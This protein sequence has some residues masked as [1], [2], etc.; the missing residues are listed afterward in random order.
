MVPP[1]DRRKTYTN[2]TPLFYGC[3]LALAAIAGLGWSAIGNPFRLAATEVI[4]LGEVRL[5][6]VAQGVI[7]VKNRHPW[8]AASVIGV[9]TDCSCVS[10]QPDVLIVPARTNTTVATTVSPRANQTRVDAIV[11]FMQT[12][13]RELH[14]KV[15]ATVVSP[16]AGWPDAAF[17]E[18]RDGMLIVSLDERYHGLVRSVQCYAPDGAG[19]G[20]RIGESRDQIVID[21]PVGQPLRLVVEFA[22]TGWALW[23]GPVRAGGAL[24]HPAGQVDAHSEMGG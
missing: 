12:T 1:E 24:V 6:D 16:F 15:E 20:S 13:D 23:D 4:R 9:A 11:R 21:A 18:P 10:I 8:A 22:G 5:G 2:R 7:Q 14:T 19:V 17:A 3:G